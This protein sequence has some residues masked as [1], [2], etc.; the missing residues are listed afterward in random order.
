[1]PRYEIQDNGGR[2]L[3]VVGAADAFDAVLHGHRAAAPIRR[4]PTLS[5]RFFGP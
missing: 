4:P 1:M 5:G 3:E 2:T